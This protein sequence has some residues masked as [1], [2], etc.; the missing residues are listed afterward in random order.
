[1]HLI[2]QLDIRH[3]L[4]EGELVEVCCHGS[5]VVL[6]EVLCEC[7][8]QVIHGVDLVKYSTHHLG[9]GRGGGGRGGGGRGEG[10]GRERGRRRGRGEGEKERKGE[11]REGGGW[12]EEG[13]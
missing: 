1:M 7:L 9:G 10:E 2:E 8:H 6:V 5:S 13:E 11:K 4:L 3:L 12:R